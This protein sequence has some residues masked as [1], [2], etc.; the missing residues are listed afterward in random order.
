[1]NETKSFKRYPAICCW[2]KHLLEGRYLSEEKILFTIFGKLKRIRNIATIV[3]K[4][5]IT[6][7][8]ANREDIYS[9]DDDTS[10]LRIEFDL[11]DGTGLIRA[12]FWSA[13]P[14]KYKNFKKGDIIDVIGLIRHWKEYI[15]IS[16]EIIKKIEDPNLI[17]LRNAEIIKKIKSGETQKIP[18]ILNEEIVID[19]ISAE[20]D[21]KD[22]FEEEQGNNLNDL[23][24]KIYTL[25]E[26]NSLDGN[27]ISFQELKKITQISEDDLRSHIRDLEMESRIYQSEENVFQIY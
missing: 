26:D 5:E 24:E 15:S 27:G 6:N 17:L 20:I 22:L 18:E 7:T 9:E 4:R 11:D 8:Q 1:M 21:V 19:E 2:I 12:I 16:P 14:E 3:D 10:N 23:K 13:N 25:I